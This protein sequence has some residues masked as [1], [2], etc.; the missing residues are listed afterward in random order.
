MCIFIKSNLITHIC[1]SYLLFRVGRCSQP[2]YVSMFDTYSNQ[3]PFL[4]V[5][6]VVVKVECNKGVNLKV[7]KWSPSILFGMSALILKDLIIGS[8]NLDSIRPS[9]DATLMLFRPDGSHMLQIP[10]KGMLIMFTIYHSLEEIHWL[11]FFFLWE[12]S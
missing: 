12:V 6:E 5:P 1:V 7:Y 9:Y 3:I 11:T 8:S 2:I 4:K 10:I